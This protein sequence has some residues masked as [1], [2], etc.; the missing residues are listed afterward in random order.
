MAI[1]IDGAVPRQCIS[2]EQFLEWW[3]DPHRHQSTG[4]L[5]PV[6]LVY[7]PEDAF[8]I[9]AHIGH[10]VFAVTGSNGALLRFRTLDHAWRAL[11]APMV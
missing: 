10:R 6:R 8:C 4:R 5:S 1:S 7:M 11:G 9:W 3:N 2:F